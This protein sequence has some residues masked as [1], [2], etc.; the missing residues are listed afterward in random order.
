MH[1]L[2]PGHRVVSLQTLQTLSTD[3][4]GG[5]PPGAH[6]SVSV[7][8]A[9]RRLHVF[10][11]GIIVIPAAVSRLLERACAQC[12]RLQLRQLLRARLVAHW[13]LLRLATWHKRKRCDH[14]CSRTDC[15]L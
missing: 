12:G 5:P 11:F 8:L 3:R 13:R 14:Y 1:T 4:L 7:L 9:A 15:L 2:Q 6:R 10:V